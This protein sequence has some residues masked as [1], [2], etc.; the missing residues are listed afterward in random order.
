VPPTA[1]ARL[2]ADRRLARVQPARR[3]NDSNHRYTTDLGVYQ[4][5]IA[6]GLEARGVVMCASGVSA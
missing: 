6:L 4:Q 3:A 2:G 1:C 5:M